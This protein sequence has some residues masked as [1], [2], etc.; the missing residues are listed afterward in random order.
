VRAFLIGASSRQIRDSSL[1]A[2]VDDIVE[3]LVG[4]RAAFDGFVRSGAIRHCGCG[5]TDCPT[6]M[7]S[8]EAARKM[9]T[10]RL[11]LLKLTHA[12]SDRAPESFYEFS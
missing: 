10:R 2:R 8:D 11:E 1:R 4:L 9:D 6:F 12:L 3:A 7:F 5:D